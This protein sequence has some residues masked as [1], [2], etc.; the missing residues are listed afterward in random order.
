MNAL[1]FRAAS[2]FAEKSF[3]CPTVVCIIVMDTFRHRQKGTGC[4]ILGERCEIDEN[5]RNP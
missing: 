5:S 3:V 2:F 1:L 4:T